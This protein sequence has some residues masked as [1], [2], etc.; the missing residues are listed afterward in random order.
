MAGRPR[1]RNSGYIRGSDP[2]YQSQRGAWPAE[3]SSASSSSSSQ[4]AERPK[5]AKRGRWITR[6]LAEEM[7]REGTL[8]SQ[9]IDEIR[10]DYEHDVLTHPLAHNAQWVRNMLNDPYALHLF[11]ARWIA[12]RGLGS[13]TRRKRRPRY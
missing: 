9:Y 12:N 2:V 5:R 1:S 3:S 4:R 6:E 10:R 11:E 7:S 13:S 8:H